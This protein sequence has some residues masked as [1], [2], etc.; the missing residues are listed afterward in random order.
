MP[1]ALLPTASTMTFGGTTGGSSPASSLHLSCSMPSP[2]CIRLSETRWQHL[3]NVIH[4]D[5]QCNLHCA[6]LCR[7]TTASL[8]TALQL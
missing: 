4:P 3:M 1:L 6:S 2:A 7:E 8:K 5:M